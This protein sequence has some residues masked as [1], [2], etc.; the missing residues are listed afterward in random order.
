[1]IYN[2]NGIIL[3][4][5]Y[6]GTYKEKEEEC[7]KLVIELQKL[8]KNNKDIKFDNVKKYNYLSTSCKI[9]DKICRVVAPILIIDIIAIP[10][11]GIITLI[12]RKVT[13]FLVSLGTMVIGSVLLNKYNKDSTNKENLE[14][15][16]MNQLDNYIDLLEK[17]K[18]NNNSANY[19]NEVIDQLE[20]IKNM[21]MQM[22]KEKN[23]IDEI[24]KEINK[25]SNKYDLESKLKY[26]FNSES[27]DNPDISQAVGVV[28][29]V[30]KSDYYTTEVECVIIGSLIG[31]VIYIDE[32][33]EINSL[34]ANINNLYSYKFNNYQEDYIDLPDKVKMKLNVGK[35]A[36]I[37]VGDIFYQEADE[38]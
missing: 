2:E 29:K 32:P 13:P 11:T 20:K 15:Q 30:I 16:Y 38:F 18:S 27:L 9:L 26:K 36:N 22:D 28:T 19:N 23:R 14:N 12:T 25:Y 4:E 34:K 1:M 8:C 21:K 17:I 24:N 37:K 5:E 33:L 31:G 7:K 6:S 35:I 10:I 3:N